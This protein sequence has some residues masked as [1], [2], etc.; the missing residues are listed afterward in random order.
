[1]GSPQRSKAWGYEV[2]TQALRALVPVFTRLR[3][4]GS[5]AYK[6]AA[7]DLVADGR[8]APILVVV[9]KDK[10]PGNPLLVTLPAQ[11]LLELVRDPR[12]HLRPVRVQ[13]KGRAQT[14]IGGLWR[15]LREAVKRERA[16]S[17]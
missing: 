13:V 14:W 16:D 5:M 12:A 10:G 8:G 1:M 6:K 3:R 15:D 2:E 11:D 17:A 7:A 9:T 4:T